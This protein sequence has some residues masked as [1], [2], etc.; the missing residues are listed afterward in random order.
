MNSFSLYFILQT[1]FVQ[2]YYTPPTIIQIQNI[3]KISFCVCFVRVTVISL[4]HINLLISFQMALV[5]ACRLISHTLAPHLALLLNMFFLDKLVPLLC[6][7]PLFISFFSN[8]V[9]FSWPH[10]SL[11]QRVALRSVYSIY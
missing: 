6:V 10:I 5:P 4:S 8:S 2:V 1:M 3:F 7:C 9:A 11:P